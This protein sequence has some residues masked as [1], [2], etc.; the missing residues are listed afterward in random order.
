MLYPI[1]A[2]TKLIDE[3]TNVAS[4]NGGNVFVGPIK[5]DPR[6]QDY[7]R[8]EVDI[9]RRDWKRLHGK[10]VELGWTSFGEDSLIHALP[11]DMFIVAQPVF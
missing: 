4:A 3:M 6:G 1:E 7:R 5:D 11:Y 9:N 2:A 10:F 8:V